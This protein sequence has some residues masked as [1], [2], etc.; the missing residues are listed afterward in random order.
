MT[1]NPRRLLLVLGL[2]TCAL[3]AAGAVVILCL[4]R[5]TR[6]PP[7]PSPNGYDDL[8]KAGRLST[9][10]DSVND[11]DHDRLR[12]L[13]ATNSKALRPLRVGLARHCAVPT[14]STIANFSTISGDLIGLRSLARVLVA[15]GRLAEIE[16]R[17]TDAAHSY[18]DAIRLGAEMSHGGLMINR[19]VGIA[20]EGMGCIP[21]VRL[22][23]RLNCEEMRPLIAQLE[24]IDTNSVKWAEVTR[25]E[26]RFVRAQAG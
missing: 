17:P 19:L 10:F 14:E 22:L 3:L 24:A 7:L 1:R 15:E 13:V 16:N 26:N 18:L 9:R 8:L 23:P 20:C 21:L 5:T 25:N 4:G 2:V 12:I 11:L 6:L